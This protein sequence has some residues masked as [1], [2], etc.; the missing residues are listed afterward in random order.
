MTITEA[1]KY[2]GVSRTIL[3][4]AIAEGRLH[5]L[6]KSTLYKGRGPTYLPRAE[7]EALRQLRDSRP[8]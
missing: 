1:A 2:L 6:P 5:P 8:G 4:R 3:Y 7:V